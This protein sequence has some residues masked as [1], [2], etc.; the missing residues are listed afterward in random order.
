MDSAVFLPEPVVSGDPS[1]A[2]GA[3]QRLPELRLDQ[4]DPAAAALFA[5]RSVEPE[6]QDAMLAGAVRAHPQSAEARLRRADW[7]IGSQPEVAAVMALLD[8]ALGVDPF[9]WRPDWYCGKLYLALGRPSEAIECFDKVYGEIP[10]EPAPKLALAMALEASGR[11][12]EAA[13]L[14]DTVSRTD[15]ALTAAAFGLARCRAAAGDRAG[16]VAALGRVPDTAALAAEA[17]LA[18]VRILSD[19]EAGEA[20][21]R[22]ASEILA[23]LNRDDLA[24]HEV[25]AAVAL[26]A[27]RQAE[28][29][30]LT[31][32]TALL[33]VP[34]TARTLRQRAEAA[35]RTCA[36]L[37]GSRFARIAY[38][39][40]AN[41]A[42]PRTLV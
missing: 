4:T 14:F 34:P 11:R 24:R 8:G 19:G 25:E 38:V 18:A 30:A 21:L 40:R 16:A 36:R 6:V 20:E 10:G 33:G 23:K 13:G 15:P 3:W 31:A 22:Q 27:A 37:S 28:K 42:R 9:D 39:D 26:Q 35:L 7:L 29:G 41:A 17:R 2:E 5:A 32:Q 12:T 1:L